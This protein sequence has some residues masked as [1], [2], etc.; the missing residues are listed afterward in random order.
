MTIAQ[1]D[2]TTLDTCTLALFGKHSGETV[3]IT[4]SYCR[5]AGDE[6]FYKTSRQPTTMDLASTLPFGE[7][8]H[9]EQG[10]L[11]GVGVISVDTGVQINPKVGNRIRIEGVL[12]PRELRAGMQICKY[13][14]RTQETCGDITTVTT[15]SVIADLYTRRGDAGG[16]AY[17]KTSATTAYA[18]GVQSGRLNE[19]AEAQ[20]A[21]RF[22]YLK[23]VFD[24]YG[25][26]PIT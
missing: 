8:T 1:P 23:P 7:Y 6:V 21:V 10:A 18:V 12:D 16:L 2:D 24:D 19:P 20:R 17:V 3:A 11:D 22:A 9:V 14:Y 4:A 15:T 26:E 5:R 13:G 25:I